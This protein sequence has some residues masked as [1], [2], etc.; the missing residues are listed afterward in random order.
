M[1]ME[2]SSFRLPKAP[3]AVEY[4]LSSN[5]TTASIVQEYYRLSKLAHPSDKE[6][7]QIG[8]IL[9]LAQYDPE[10]SSLINEADHLIAY[11][12]G[13]SQDLGTRV[14]IKYQPDHLHQQKIQKL[15]G[16]LL[17]RKSLPKISGKEKYSDNQK[18]PCL[19]NNC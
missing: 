13:L 7:N 1:C 11:E 18:S 15:I 16:T 9:E 2:T 12:L 8:V 19:S 17:N 6:L 3:R 5:S 14:K 4:N 10:L